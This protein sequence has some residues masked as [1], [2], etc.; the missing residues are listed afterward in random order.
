MTPNTYNTI[1][2]KYMTDVTYKINRKMVTLWNEI[3]K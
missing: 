1:N 3:N 2:T